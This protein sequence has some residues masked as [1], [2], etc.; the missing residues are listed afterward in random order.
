[1]GANQTDVP[2]KAEPLLTANL[3][4]ST[5]NAS[6]TSGGSCVI[7]KDISNGLARVADAIS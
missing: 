6:T 5:V 3:L 4:T 1:M 7:G 2:I